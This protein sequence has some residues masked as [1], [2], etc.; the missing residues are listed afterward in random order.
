[1]RNE[2]RLGLEYINKASKLKI[3]CLMSR[4]KIDG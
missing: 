1:M 3:G 4:I 2:L